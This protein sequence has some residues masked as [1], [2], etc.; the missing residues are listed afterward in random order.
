M[1]VIKKIQLLFEVD[2]KEA[3]EEIRET[4]Q[5]VKNVETNMEDVAETGDIFTGGMISQFKA[6]ANKNEIIE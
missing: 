5:E 4:S 2:N 3:I 6:V 1:S